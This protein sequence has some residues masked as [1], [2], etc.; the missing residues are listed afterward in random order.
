MSKVFTACPEGESSLNAGEDFGALSL[1]SLCLNG[2]SAVTVLWKD[3][4]WR[5]GLLDDDDVPACLRKAWITM[6][7]QRVKFLI[8]PNVVFVPTNATKDELH[9][10]NSALHPSNE[11][12]SPTP[13]PF[14]PPRPSHPLPAASSN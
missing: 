6:M 10:P 7:N 5:S 1:P 12:N 8:Y 11:P 2:D 13:H 9:S 14:H 4:G 3:S